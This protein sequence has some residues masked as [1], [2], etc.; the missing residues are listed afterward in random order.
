MSNRR[1]SVLVAGLAI[2]ACTRTD[3]P[4]APSSPVAA[5]SGRAS[6]TGAFTITIDPAAY[7]GTYSVYGQLGIGSGIRTVDLDPGEYRLL[8]GSFGDIHFTV[9]AD[10]SVTSGNTAAA[11]AGGSTLTLHTTN[12]A[13]NTNGYALWYRVGDIGPGHMGD[14]T[15]AVIPTVQNIVD[16]GSAILESQMYFIADAAGNV[17]ITY[18]PDAAEGGAGTLTFHTTLVHIIPS[19]ASAAWQVYPST[20]ASG[21]REVTLVTGLTFTVRMT[22]PPGGDQRIAVGAPCSVTPAS[23]TIATTSFTAGCGPLPPSDL[24]P[25]VIVPTV[26]GT[27]GNNGWYRSDV[28][29]TWSVTDAESGIAS[30]TGCGAQT[31]T[32]DAAS[33]TYTCSAT[34]GVSL[35]ASQSVT[36]KRDAT[37]PVVSFAGNAGSYTVD[38]AV[39]IS[40]SATDNLSGVATNG[41][42]SA[43]G[44]AYAFGAGPHALNAAAQDAAGN[45]AAAST[46]FTVVVD[47]EGLSALVRRFVSNDGLANSLI[48]KLRAAD[49]ARARG[50]DKAAANQLNAFVNEVQAQSGKGIAAADAAVLVAL[51]T[52]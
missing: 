20:A 50:N 36:V 12:V 5:A 37:P 48:A 18:A 34:N 49:S 21:A 31:L 47:L 8:A 11:G 3:R 7:L 6:S 24:T 33:V 17:T 9:A 30:S 51:A 32:A 19:P 39:A 13:F 16:F 40:C 44:P 15:V 52:P 43:A 28:G 46:T 42:V 35:S 14:A 41:C 2:A 22:T 38:Q 25:P 4:V 1:L 29:V 27:L 10:G 45:S 26:T 23:F